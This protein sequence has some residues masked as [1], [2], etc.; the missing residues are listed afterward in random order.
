[1]SGQDTLDVSARRATRELA[2]FL[3]HSAQQRTGCASDKFVPE[4][5]TNR[6]KSCVINPCENLTMQPEKLRALSA[7]GTPKIVFDEFDHNNVFEN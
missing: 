3:D 4:S 1:M 6:W 5:L 7:V 2:H